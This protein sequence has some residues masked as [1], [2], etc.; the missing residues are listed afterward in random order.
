MVGINAWFIIEIFSFYGYILA[1]ILFIFTNIVKSSWGLLDKSKMKNRG[2]YDFII[3]HRLDIDWAAFVQILFNVNV[4]LL[5]ID[6]FILYDEITG[7]Q[8]SDEFPLLPIQCL[9]LVNHALQMIFLRI[10]FDKDGRVNT[11]GNWVW[12]VHLISYAFVVYVYF[13]TEAGSKDKS[14]SSR[15][16]IP[17]DIVLTISM[18]LYNFYYRYF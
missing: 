15:M 9:L 13:F 6:R 16:W 2:E 17:L 3:Y 1:A 18:G 11:S 4:G 7:K 10:L 8:L 14:L 12:I 5:C